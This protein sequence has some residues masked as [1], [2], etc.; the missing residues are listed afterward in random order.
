LKGRG[1]RGIVKGENII[2]GKEKR[3]EVPRRLKDGGKK[4]PRKKRGFTQ[5]AEGKTLPRQKGKVRPALRG[6]ACREGNRKKKR[7]RAHILK[8]RYA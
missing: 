3:R 6:K 2:E 7:K 1:G 8:K 5:A 4:N